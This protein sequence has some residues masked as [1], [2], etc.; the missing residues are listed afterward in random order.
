MSEVKYTQD[1]DWLRLHGDGTASVGI[2][3]FAQKQLGDLVYVGLPE[4][5]AAFEKGADAAVIESV[6]AASDLKMPVAGTIVEVNT[7]LT[8]DPGRVNADPLGDGWFVKIK[9]S[10]PND[11]A[12]LM[13]EA[14]YE[15]FV[16]SLE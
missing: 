9:V 10:D 11:A 2:T 12:D 7:A 3:D 4:V 5:G 13:D 14:A 8:D 1:H 6:K 16:D 15:K